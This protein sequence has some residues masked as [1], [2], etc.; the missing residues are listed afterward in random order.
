MMWIVVTISSKFLAL[1]YF[2]DMPPR[3]FQKVESLT[4]QKIY[5]GICHLKWYRWTN[6]MDLAHGLVWLHLLPRWYRFTTEAGDQLYRVTRRPCW[7]NKVS[8][9][10]VSMCSLRSHIVQYFWSRSVTELNYCTF[11][12]LQRTSIVKI[13]RPRFQFWDKC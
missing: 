10:F 11:V 7:M 6:F 9:K 5:G 12:S 8:L 1:S 2:F 3:L 4:F 13:F